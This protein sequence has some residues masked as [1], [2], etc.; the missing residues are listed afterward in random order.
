[1]EHQPYV[2]SL[3]DADHKDID[4][5]EASMI[6]EEEKKSRALMGK[7]WGKA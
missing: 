7:D 5:E 3:T 1:M 4:T 2:D 6:K